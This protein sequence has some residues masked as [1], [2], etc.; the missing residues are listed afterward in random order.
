MDTRSISACKGCP[1]PEITFSVPKPAANRV[2]A[3]VAIHAPAT[4]TESFVD[5]LIDSP[6]VPRVMRISLQIL[7]DQDFGNL[8]AVEC[9]AL[10][11]IVA[12]HPKI[13]PKRMGNIFT[14]PA[15]K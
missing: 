2:A 4:P 12:D 6:V 1:R 13:E 9:R 10:A 14:N 3:L 5:L 11:D 7:L 15:D 8:N